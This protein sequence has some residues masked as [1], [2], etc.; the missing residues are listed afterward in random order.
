ME[1][2]IVL[3][4]SY[5]AHP[6]HVDF[7]DT[8][9]NPH[10]TI[11]LILRRANQTQ[12]QKGALTHAE[13]AAQYGA[14]TDD[15]QAVEDF[16]QAHGFSVDAIHVG[17]RTVKISGALEKLATAFGVDD[18]KMVATSHGVFRSRQGS[19]YLHPSLSGAVVAVLGFDKRPVA[20]SHHRV[21]AKTQQSVSY[22][23]SQVAKAYNF[24]A[25]N[26]AGQTVGLIE[27]GGGYKQ[28]DLT[29]YW[30]LAG[31]PP[32]SV[33]AVGVD[34]G[35]NAP[36]GDPNSADGE[37]CLDIEVVGGIAPGI[38]IAVYFAGNTDA[39]FLDAI[40]A[41]IHDTL[42]KPSVISISWG[43]PESSWT[44]Q[45]M[46]AYNSAF[47][48]A[49]LLGITVCAASGDNGADDGVGDGSP[50]TDFPASSPWV[51]GCG[52]TSLQLNADGSIASEVVWNDGQNGGASGGGESIFFARPMYYQAGINLPGNHRG[53]PDVAANA[54]P[55]TGW[56]VIVDGQQTVIGGT[57]A[58]APCIA[59]LIAICNMHLKASTGWP[60]KV[61]YLANG[62]QAF[63]DITS[64]NNSVP[65]V[66]Q[67]YNAEPGWDACTGLGSPNGVKVLTLLQEHRGAA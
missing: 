51:L 56:S 31:V 59:S 23:P 26:G 10:S 58:A 36:S 64:G 3:S 14:A 66:V 34:G 52:G 38:K 21:S 18:L 29:A 60:G 44:A 37:V 2:K 54:D 6:A 39:G 61:F 13:H 8:V 28:S 55:E 27:L 17:S 40:N 53:V 5:R 33:T 15:I 24:P 63:H 32:V 41:A 42:R 50:H 46:N 9:G 16:A 30:K 47:H 11:T 35:S 65:N 19:I 20:K 12:D 62:P 1:E 22:I 43:G 57:S 48:D 49:A 25:G 45:A 4:G 67:G 7:A